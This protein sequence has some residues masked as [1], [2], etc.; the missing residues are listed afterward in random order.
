[1]ARTVTAF[2]ETVLD[3]ADVPTLIESG[4]VATVD[5][6]GNILITLKAKG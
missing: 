1:M 6:V 5:P 3:P 4:C 2:S